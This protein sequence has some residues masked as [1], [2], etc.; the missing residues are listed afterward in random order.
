[1]EVNDDKTVSIGDSE[2]ALSEFFYRFDVKGEDG[3]ALP[4]G[5]KLTI[6]G[7][8]ELYTLLSKLATSNSAVWGVETS[9]ATSGA[10]G[11]GD[12][13]PV[14]LI[15]TLTVATVALV[16]VVAKKRKEN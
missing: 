10:T 6:H 7:A 12:V 11:T 8:G 15:A 9:Y 16:V 13:L 5:T 3:N 2:V 1:M 4:K 14:A